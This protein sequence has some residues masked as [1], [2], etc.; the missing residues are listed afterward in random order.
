MRKLSFLGFLKQYLPALSGINSLNIRAL[1]Q[2]SETNPRLREPLFLYVLETD[3]TAALERRAKPNSCFAAWCAGVAR[4]FSQS[5]AQLSERCAAYTERRPHQNAHV[6]KNPAIAAGEASDQ[7]P[8][9]HGTETKSGKHQR[10]AK[11][12]RLPEGQLGYSP[13]CAALRSELSAGMNFCA[14]LLYKTTSWPDLHRSGF[15]FGKEK[16]NGLY[17]PHPRA[18]PGQ[19]GE[20]CAR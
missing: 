6:G 14:F 11:T 9:V 18:P 15:F 1:M 12:W 17:I 10:L 7:L 4:R 19:G 16:G 20:I 13:S 3:K 8:C 5:L 2:M